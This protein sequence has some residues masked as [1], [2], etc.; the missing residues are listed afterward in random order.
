MRI[1][2]HIYVINVVGLSQT[3]ILVLDTEGHTRRYVE[4]LK[5][6]SLVNPKQ[7]I[8]PIQLFLMTSITQMEISKL[9]VRNFEPF[10]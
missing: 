9:Q 10:A 8:L 4:K 5:D 7:A 3:H 2:V 1:M 6:I